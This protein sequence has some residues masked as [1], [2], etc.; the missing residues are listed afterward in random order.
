QGGLDAHTALDLVR[1]EVQD[2]VPRINPAQAVGQTCGM[3]DDL[4]QL[5]LAGAPMGDE[6]HVPQ[7]I[8]RVALHERTPFAGCWRHE[9]RPAPRVP[10]FDEIRTLVEMIRSSTGM[11]RRPAPV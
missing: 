2:A 9:G 11:R 5:R 7:A 10:W 1:V 6:G 8:N 4:G 3:Q